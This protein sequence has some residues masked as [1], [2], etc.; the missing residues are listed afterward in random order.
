MKLNAP[1]IAWAAVIAT[2]VFFAVCTSFFAL[3][4]TATVGFIGY[5]LH[6][7][8]TGISRAPAWASSLVGTVC[9]ALYA[10]LFAAFW[11]D[12]TIGLQR[13]EPRHGGSR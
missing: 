10:A 5:V 12:C 2:A 7:D 4:P 8:L 9:V 11:A 6:L 1:A 3:A 13:L